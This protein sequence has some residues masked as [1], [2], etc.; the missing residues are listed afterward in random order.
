VLRRSFLYTRDH[1]DETAAFTQKKHPQQVVAVEGARNRVVNRFMF[2]FT[3][4]DRKFGC[5]DRQLLRDTFKWATRAT[6]IDPTMDP[7]AVIDMS[8]LPPV[9]GVPGC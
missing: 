1:P 3:D 6:R 7:E 9:D 4:A 2:S 8:Y 5:F